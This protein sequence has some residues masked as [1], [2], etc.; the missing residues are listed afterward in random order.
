[1]KKRFFPVLVF[2]IIIV[3]LIL[4]TLRCIYKEKVDLWPSDSRVFSLSPD[5]NGISPGG[6]VSITS[7]GE[8]LYLTADYAQIFLLRGEDGSLE[9][10]RPDR[11]TFLPEKQ[12]LTYNPTGLFY[13]NS[14]RLLY[15]ANYTANNILAFEVNIEARSLV[16]KSEIGTARTVSPENVSLSPDGSFLACANY[17]GSS[18]TAFDL[19]GKIAQEL[20]S[21]PIKLAHGVCISGEYVYA[22]GL[23]SRALFELNR[24]NG[25]IQRQ[26]GQMGWNPSKLDLLW[27]TSVQ[28]FSPDELIMSDAHTGYIYLVDRATLKVKRYFGGNG[29]T[30]HHL[31]M[32]YA[33]FVNGDVIGIVSTYQRRVL[34]GNKNEFKFLH[35][36]SSQPDCW[37]YARSLTS[38]EK[39]RLGIGWDNYYWQ[40]GPRVNLLGNDYILGYAHLHPAHK[41]L[42]SLMTPWRNPSLF[43]SI[44]ELYFLD[45]IE[46]PE[47]FI[48]FTSQRAQAYCVYRESD[49]TYFLPLA[50]SPD[51][52]RI[53]REL[54]SPEGKRDCRA[55]WSDAGAKVKSLKAARN[56]QG[57]LN[58]KAL[59]QIVFP[60][61]DKPVFEQQ[62]REVF[63]TEAGNNFYLKYMNFQ[64]GSASIDELNQGAEVFFV[65][66]AKLENI[67]MEELMLVHM[68]TGKIP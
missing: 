4:L 5:M 67:P 19:T 12:G 68:L 48:L 15:V 27:P 10:M 46:F 8:G 17:D 14:H 44:G 52:W 50:L 1:M 18:V 47:G 65:E 6:M 43:N 24:K 45:S 20:W 42:A 51:N 55:I 40:K 41:R 62:F 57:V 11:S 63:R 34:L 7:P 64:S 66:V 2:S 39:Q 38:I 54:F 22:T 32:P 56:A 53:G 3:P 36:Y 9:L 61:I 31:N 49:A 58:S 25:H 33:A 35:S 30:F 29:P 21:T 23:H 60:N 16:L 59:H 28:E 13:D 26:A 37:E